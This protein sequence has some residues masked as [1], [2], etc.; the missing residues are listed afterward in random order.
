MNWLSAAGPSAVCAVPSGSSCTWVQEIERKKCVSGAPSQ[1]SIAAAS[2]DGSSC[3]ASSD[4]APAEKV[5]SSL[6]TVSLQ[7]AGK[8]AKPNPSTP[9]LERQLR[10]PGHH[11]QG[12]ESQGCGD[13]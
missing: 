1:R 11:E 13:Q 5:R 10:E 3:L 8:G 12:R 9:T 4:S 7:A 2:W 6:G